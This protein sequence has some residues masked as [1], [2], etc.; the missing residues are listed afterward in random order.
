[1]SDLRHAFH[2]TFISLQCLLE[3]FLYELLRFHALEFVFRERAFHGECLEQF[4][5]EALEVLGVLIGDSC[6]SI[7]NRVQ[8]VQTDTLSHQGV[9]TAGVDY[10]TLRVHHVVVFQQTFTDTEVVFLY[11]LLGTFYGLA[12]HIVLQ[13]LAFLETKLIHQAGDLLGSE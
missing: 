1:M 8:Y 7:V 2:T 9:A 6:R 13:N 10:V 3:Q 12:Q 5:L 11:L 4:Q